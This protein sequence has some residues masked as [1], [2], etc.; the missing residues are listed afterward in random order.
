MTLPSDNHVHTEFSWDTGPDASMVNTCRRAV[1][2]GLPAVSFTEH[3]D[4]TDWGDH[5][6]PPVDAQVGT[7][8]RVLPVDVDGYLASIERCR[9]EFPEL[10]ILSG[11]EAGEPHLFAG[12]VAAVLRSG[13][14]DRV[15]G[16]LHSIVHDGKLVYA[17]H[18]FRSWPAAEVVRAYFAEL[19]RLVEGSNM[20]EVLAHCDYPRRYWP[21]AREGEY[22]EADFE[23]EYRTVFRALAS[24]DRPLEI[25]TSSPLASVSLMR[26][27]Y[28]E[29]GGAV[30]FGSDAHVP[31]RV[32]D[33]FDVAVDVVEAAGFRPG[34]DEYDF[35]RR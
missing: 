25:N 34:R 28:E 8:K 33:K 29:G 12:S 3:V 23:E 21:A 35:W 11:I 19:L 18:V 13:T 17:N 4:F 20:F 9:H 24:S 26:W 16:S 32:G 30:S 1:E 2:I 7:R 5:D 31:V 14:F 10:R 27:W 22:R 15:L 6:H